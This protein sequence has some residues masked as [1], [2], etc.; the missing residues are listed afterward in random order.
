MSSTRFND[1]LL[2]VRSTTMYSP[3]GRARAR[4]YRGSF[5]AERGLVGPAPRPL[6][7]PPPARQRAQTP[8]RCSRSPPIPQ[9][10]RGRPY[11]RQPP[12]P[13]GASTGSP[14]RHLPAVHHHGH[15][16]PPTDRLPA[17]NP[18][19]AGVLGPDDGD[20]RSEFAR[21]NTWSR[22]ALRRATHPSVQSSPRPPSPWISMSPP[23][24][25]TRPDGHRAWTPRTRAGRLR[26]GNSGAGLC[27]TSSPRAPSWRRR[28]SGPRAPHRRRRGTFPRPSC[29]SNRRPY[30]ESGGPRR[31]STGDRLSTQRWPGA[32]RAAT[33]QSFPAPIAARSGRARHRRSGSPPR[34]ETRD[35]VGRRVRVLGVR[36][37]EGGFHLVEK[38]PGLIEQQL[39]P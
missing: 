27:N 16:G 36:L 1:S 22:S 39:H 30:A 25:P 37:C 6:R 17:P 38:C 32:L 33:S 10:R 21:A 14:L 8:R 7:R 35:L 26:W 29:R 12:S 24:R 23:M 11:R 20:R 28:G 9:P 13:G 31:E 3:L 2:W 15:Y 4:R 5:G 34:W 19:G 18:H